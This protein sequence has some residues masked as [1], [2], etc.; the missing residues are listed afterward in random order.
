M[1]C[2]RTLR[3]LAFTLAAIAASTARADLISS[4]DA[5]LE[6]WTGSGGTVS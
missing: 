4:F 5:G 1:T 2:T 6:G 3:L